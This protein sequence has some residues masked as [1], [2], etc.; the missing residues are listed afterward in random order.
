MMC[1]FFLRQPCSF[2]RKPCSSVNEIKH[3]AL[4]LVRTLRAR[5]NV[6][7]WLLNVENA[8]YETIKM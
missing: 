6:E 1:G 7:S 3:I 2:L 4:F 5:G 8:M